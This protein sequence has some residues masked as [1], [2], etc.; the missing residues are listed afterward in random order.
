MAPRL[1]ALVVAAA[2]GA[3]GCLGP[4]GGG[5]ERS[6]MNGAPAA[7]RVQRSALDVRL[8][9]L[10]EPRPERAAAG[11]N[12]FRFGDRAAGPPT[13]TA[14]VDRQVRAGS[15]AAPP[16]PLRLIGVVD[17]PES[18]GPIAVLADGA[19]VFQGRVGDTVAGR[20]RII[21]IAADTVEVELLVAGGQRILRLDGLPESGTP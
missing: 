7:D 11:R 12:P 18:A 16:S 8:E 13:P 14:P 3:A 6:G 10:S 1:L 17:A 20:Y 4:S 9:A 19:G 21:R 15:R 5:A 2:A